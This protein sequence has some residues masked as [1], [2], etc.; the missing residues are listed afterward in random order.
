M[1][2]KGSLI[3]F[4]LSGFLYSPYGACDTSL[5]RV[6][7]SRQFEQAK[8][9]AESREITTNLGQNYAYIDGSPENGMTIIYETVSSRTKY[10]T[11][12]PITKVSAE[13][14]SMDCSYIRAVDDSTGAVSVGGFCRGT[15]EA[16]RDSIEGTVSEQNLLAYSSTAPWLEKVRGA[17]D[18]KLPYGFVY[19]NVYFV[20]CQ[21]G[22]E[23]G[24]TANITITAFSPGFGKLFTV[25]GYE[26]APLKALGSTEK[27][28]FWGLRKNSA[29]EI[30]E[31]E[32]S[33]ARPVVRPAKKQMSVPQG[34]P[35]V[36]SDYPAKL[37]AGDI[38]LPDEFKAAPDGLSWRDSSGKIMEKP[39]IN[40]SGKYFLS[41]H[42]CGA[43]CRYYLMFDLSTGKEALSLEMFAS[44][45]PPPRT[46]E[47]YR[48]I[49][50]L[51]SKADSNMLVAQYEIQKGEETECRERIFV[52]EDDKI[53][54]I[55]GIRHSCTSLE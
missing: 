31:R 47:G 19:S 6:D 24:L 17:V 25:S 35:P 21:N 54:P 53:K 23:D 29:H 52:L 33:S 55:T 13:S 39:G 30:M 20:R 10:K 44:T 2:I 4:A 42:S 5:D 37:Y 32:L 40:F 41:A 50:F 27:V 7:F 46:R 45:E 49:T 15:S 36:F 51:Y 14:L 28:V 16:T 48:Y 34:K 1:K 38:R 26:L 9:V 43:E 8:A 3:V 12:T 11:I 22:E 18:C